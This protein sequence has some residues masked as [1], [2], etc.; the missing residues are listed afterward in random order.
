MFEAGGDHR[1]PIE[2]MRP[3]DG[4]RPWLRTM[5]RGPQLR[6][7]IAE[8]LKQL[9][10]VVLEH[11]GSVE[12]GQYAFGPVWQG[13]VA[14]V[15]GPVPRRDPS[16]TRVVQSSSSSNRPIFLERINR[17]AAES[18]RDDVRSG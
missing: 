18:R 15:A 13:Q 5:D 16:S 1:G 12:V 3:T 10:T 9:I 17:R 8:A 7:V 6:I 14:E 4:G 11:R 2:A